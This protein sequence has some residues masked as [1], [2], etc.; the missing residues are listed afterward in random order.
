MGN[1]AK[2]YINSIQTLGAV[3]G[4]G[5]R[6]VVFMQGCPLKCVCCHNPETHKMGVGE[7]Y[8]P[9]EIAERVKKYK[10][11]FGESGGITLSGGEPL[12]QASFAT[13]LFKLCKSSGINTCLDT[14]GCVYNESVDRLLDYCDLVLLDIK[15]TD[16]K[17]YAENVGCELNTILDFLKIL[18]KRG[19]P[20][21][22]RQVIIPG[23][24]DTEKN[25]EKLKIIANS[26]KCVQKTELLPL[27]KL[28]ETKYNN[29]GLEFPLKSTPEP[30]PELMEKLNNLLNNKDIRSE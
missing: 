8:T 6:F 23:L 20:T 29:M 12:M 17:G 21:W 10:E 4:P 28:C 1:Q 11:Y 5:V 22:L 18:D 25:I 2:G 3:D 24:N 30:T 16:N 15:Y 7:C 27:K 9:E 19:I 14:S 26:H 13:K